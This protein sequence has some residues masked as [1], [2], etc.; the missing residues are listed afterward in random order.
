MRRSR[1]S[2]PTC[3]VFENGKQIDRMYPAR[4][5]FA[6]HEDEPTTEVAIRRAVSED[7]YLVLGSYNV[8]TQEATYKIVINPLVN[9]IWFG[10][11]VMALGTGARAAARERIRVCRQPRFPPAR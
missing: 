11:A 7:L 3:R 2:L 9:W 10:F 5:F 8:S 1:W 4:W 6:K